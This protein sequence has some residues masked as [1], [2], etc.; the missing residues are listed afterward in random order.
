[1]GC[2]KPGRGRQPISAARG[3]M[4]C[5]MQVAGFP[6]PSFLD[7]PFLYPVFAIVTGVSKTPI[8]RAPLYG[9]HGNSDTSPKFKPALGYRNGVFW[10]WRDPGPQRRGPPQWPNITFFISA[11]Y[12][13]RRLLK[14][15]PI[16][17]LFFKSDSSKCEFSNAVFDQIRMTKGNRI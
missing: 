8:Y 2:G 6:L 1:M 16:T 3:S 12:I 4:V 11:N 15:A 5:R 10:L 13:R 14:N 9:K 7:S 17:V